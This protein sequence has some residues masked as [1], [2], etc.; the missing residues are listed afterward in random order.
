MA[1]LRSELLRIREER[2]K[3]TAAAVLADARDPESP[4]HDRFTWADDEA[5]EHWRLHE[6]RTLIR[7]V[8]IVYRAPSGEARKVREF[9]S[10]DRPELGE[11]SYEPVDTILADP[12][13]TKILMRQ[14]EREWRSLKDRYERFAEFR[15]LVARDL[16]ITG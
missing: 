3:L 7:L 15:E 9:H 10:I 4:L 5:A 1:D 2:G 6:A 13:Q 14:M 8:K 16:E 12:L 11:R